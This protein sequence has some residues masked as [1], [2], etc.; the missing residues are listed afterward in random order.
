MAIA[1]IAAVLAGQARFE[2]AVRGAVAIELH[3]LQESDEK[4]TT[5]LHGHEQR[6]AALEH[7]QEQVLLRLERMS[8][9]LE[10]NGKTVDRIEV[11]LTRQAVRR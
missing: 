9:T 2:T 10:A 11:M 5:I 7:A 6:L 4:A 1:V 3:A 8:T